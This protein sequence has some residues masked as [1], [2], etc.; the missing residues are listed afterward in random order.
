MSDAFTNITSM[1]GSGFKTIGKGVLLEW[2]ISGYVL[3]A[4]AI[5]LAIV[6]PFYR[7]IK[8]WKSQDKTPSVQV[9]SGG[10]SCRSDD[11]C[12]KPNGVCTGLIPDNT[13]P[14]NRSPRN[15]KSGKCTCS[16]GF[17]HTPRAMAGQRVNE[18]TTTLCPR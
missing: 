6:R 16:G 18:W 8:W 9:V 7:F 3:V 2:K 13:T 14:E 4:I 5:F 15:I 12:N 10:G 17:S 11:F 1:A